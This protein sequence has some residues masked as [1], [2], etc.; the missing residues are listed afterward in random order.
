MN[1]QMSDD[2]HQP[3]LGMQRAASHSRRVFLL[4]VLCGLVPFFLILLTLFSKGEEAALA[5]F[6]SALLVELLATLLLVPL[7]LFARSR[8]LASGLFL[9][10]PRPFAL[11]EPLPVRASPGLVTELETPALLPQECG[12]DDTSKRKRHNT[13]AANVV[14]WPDRF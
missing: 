8:P 6:L 3:S 4:G 10:F 2:Q 13:P 14:S 7:S 12:F 5:G 11:R 9:F 1:Q